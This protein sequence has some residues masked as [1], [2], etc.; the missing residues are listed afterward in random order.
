M[1]YR[2][3]KK[4]AQKYEAEMNP[5][6]LCRRGAWHVFFFQKELLEMLPFLGPWLH[7]VYKWTTQ[8]WYFSTDLHMWPLHKYTLYSYYFVVVYLL[9]PIWLFATPMDCSMPGFPVLHYLL[10]FAQTYV[11]WVIGDAIQTSHLLFSPSSPD[12]NLSQHQGSQMSWLFTPGSQSIHG[13]F[14][15]GLIVLVSLHSKGLSRVFS[16][17]T[18]QK[19]QFFNTQPSWSNS[20]ICTWLGKP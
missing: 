20:H 17:T 19:H 16:S 13:W 11:H 9:S 3:R 4:W 8:S 10:E 12:F 15:L 7:L 5:A 14:P 2:Y 18:V 6:I 1:W